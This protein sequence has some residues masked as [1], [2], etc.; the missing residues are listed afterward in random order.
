MRFCQT[1]GMKMASLSKA[2]SSGYF[3]VA[4]A[5]VAAAA[6]ELRRRRAVVVLAAVGFFSVSPPL[7]SATHSHAPVFPF[8]WTRAKATAEDAQL[9]C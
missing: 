4:V 7:V 8:P 1:A 5:A 9:Y 3:A 6:E 2:F